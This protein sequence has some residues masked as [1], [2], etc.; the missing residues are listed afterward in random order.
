MVSQEVVFPAGTTQRNVSIPIMDDNVLEDMESFSVYVS[1]QNDSDGVMLG[2]KSV[3]V[4]IQNNDS[5][6]SRSVAIGCDVESNSCS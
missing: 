1:V 5:E 3:E 6:F 4:F 2:V